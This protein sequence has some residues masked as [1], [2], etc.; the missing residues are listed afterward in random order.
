MQI[1]CS[2]IRPLVGVETNW[3]SSQAVPIKPRDAWE[4]CDCCG[5]PGAA[6][7]MYYDGKLFLCLDCRQVGPVVGEFATLSSVVED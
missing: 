1:H 6:S 5:R 7:Q 3:A 4:I 2:T